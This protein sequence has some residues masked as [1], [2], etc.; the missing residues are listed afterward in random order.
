MHEQAAYPEPGEREPAPATLR[1]VQEF[2]NTNDIEGA[3]D[4]LATPDLLHG[5]LVQRG[6]LGPRRFGAAGRP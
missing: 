4:A 3:Q 2:V 1:L 5:W 6:L